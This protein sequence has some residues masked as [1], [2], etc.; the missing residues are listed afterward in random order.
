ML[1]LNSFTERCSC[2]TSDYQIYLCEIAF[3]NTKGN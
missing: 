3:S 1:D 2:G